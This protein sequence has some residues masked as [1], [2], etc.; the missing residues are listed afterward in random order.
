VVADEPLSQHLPPWLRRGTLALCCA[1]LFLPA[2]RI[3]RDLPIYGDDHSSHLAAI[4]HLLALL[5]AGQTDLFCPT[6]NLGFPMYLY[7]QPLPHVTAALVHLLSLGALSEQLAF[8]LTVVALWCSYPVAVYVGTRRLGLGDAAALCAA[9]SAPLLSSSLPFGLTL[10]SVMGL[11]LYTQLYAMVLFTPCLGWIWSGLHR[12]DEVAAWRAILPGAAL[13]SLVWL[14]HAFYGVAASTAALVMVLVAPGRWRRTTPRLACLALL[15][16]ATLL[17]WLAPMAQTHAFAGGWPW[18]SA[19]RWDGY[20]ASRVMRELLLG[21]LFDA[22]QPPLLSLALLGG[23]IVAARGWRAAPVRRAL[24]VGFALFLFFL[25]GRRTFGHL[26]EVQP[27]NLGLQLFRYVGPLHALGVLLAGAGLAALARALGRYIARP[28]AAFGLVLLLLVPSLVVVQVISRDLFHTIRSYSVTEQDLIATGGAIRAAR[29]GG[30]P[31]GRVYTHSKS[32]HGSHL[33]A[34]L[35]AL[36]TDQPLGQS[37]GVGM[38]DSLGF[39][40]LEF[41]DGL[42]PTLRALYNFR[43]ALA[44]PDSPLARQQLAEGNPPLLRRGELLLF[45]LRGRYGYFELVDLPLAIVGGPRDVRPAV[46]RWLGA[47][48]PAARQFGVIAPAVG[49]LPGGPAATTLRSRWRHGLDDLAQ[50]VELLEGGAWRTLRGP[51]PAGPERPPLGQVL[52]ER[53][54]LNRYEADVELIR[55]GAVALKVIYHPFW[56]AAVDGRRAPTLMLTPSYLGVRL[57]PGGHVVSF[58]FRAPLYAKLLLLGAA[59]LW[60]GLLLPALARRRRGLTTHGP[61]STLVDDR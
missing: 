33:V 22:H 47:A 44:K 18:E 53:A 42:D 23:L 11:G 24:I 51:L 45:A 19:D 39:F 40:Y 46:L 54:G 56:E 14:S 36:Y 13:L 4:H 48:L 21:R 29:Q 60:T 50:P 2:T 55:A 6:F 7:Y 38:H 26:V 49:A 3:L 20:G 34:A 31:P 17:F 10:H 27:A 15:V 30:T 28:N 37:Y 5:R 52:G 9:L 25:I 12:R 43:Y 57:P 41:F 58:R 61:A 8:N 1:L 59:L 32:G 35:Q 16:L